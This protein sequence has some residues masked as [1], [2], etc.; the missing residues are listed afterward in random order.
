MSQ[1]SIETILRGP[2]RLAALAETGLLDAASLESLERYTRLV[3]NSI[4]ASV[5]LVSLVDDHRQFFAAQSGLEEPWATARETPLSHSIC[6]HVVH[7]QLPVVVADTTEDERLV[8]NRAID[9][10]GVVAYAGMPIQTPDGHV[11]GSFCAIEPKKREWTARELDIMRDLA[12]AVS[13]EIDLRRRARRAE[14]SERRLAA[15]NQALQE[16]SDAAASST[17][18]VV[19]DIRTPLSVLALGVSHLLSHNA[20]RSFPE[21][22]KLLSTLKRNVDHATSLIGSM[23]DIARLAGEAEE[24]SEPVAP[25]KLNSLTQDVCTDLGSTSTVQLELALPSDFS[26]RVCID[27]T[28]YRRIVENLVSNALR[29][30]SGR[31]RVSLRHSD[32]EAELV[33]D[34][35]GPGLPTPDAYRQ[36]WEASARFHLESGRSG[37]GLGTAIV[38]ETVER[39]DGRVRARRSPLGGARFAVTL[40][41]A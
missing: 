13:D 40:P 25:L 41:L 16:S 4:G 28:S 14:L 17:R 19:H 8:G 15:V 26:C 27:P 7:E 2:E 29:F 38:R 24:V 5:A 6:K 23:Q 3:R 34:D 36:V 21:L 32:D 22:A 30:A 20:S 18:A 31:V 12:A 39:L 10:L 11:L 9:E 35:D 33:V 37:S 1:T